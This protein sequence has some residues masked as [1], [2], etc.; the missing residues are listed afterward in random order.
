MR[1]SCMRVG[2]G[3]DRRTAAAR[4]PYYKDRSHSVAGLAA[5]CRTSEP[6]GEPPEGSTKVLPSGGSPPG[7]PACVIVKPGRLLTCPAR[8]SPPIEGGLD[9]HP[10]GGAS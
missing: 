10:P 1:D 7:S 2:R 5:C 9:P 8:P 4:A 3:P 6:G